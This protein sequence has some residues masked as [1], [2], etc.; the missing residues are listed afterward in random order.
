MTFEE[1]EKRFTYH[2]PKDVKRGPQNQLERY[3]MIRDEG[4]SFA[5]LIEDLCPESREKSLAI[6]K[7]EEVVM[8]S[9]A[10]IARNE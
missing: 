5:C 2:P 3:K 10:S 9:N 8:W 4:F 6:T 1:L 7:L